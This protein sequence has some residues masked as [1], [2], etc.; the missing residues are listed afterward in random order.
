[1]VS[2]HETAD[3]RSLIQILHGVKEFEDLWSRAPL[4]GFRL[5]WEAVG[6]ARAFSRNPTPGRLGGRTNR[7]ALA[8]G[9][10]RFGAWRQANQASHGQREGSDVRDRDW[11]ELRGSMPVRRGPGRPWGGRRRQRSPCAGLPQAL[12]EAEMLLLPIR[13]SNFERGTGV[14]AF[15]GE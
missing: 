6:R 3:K 8:E 13:K 11:P 5:R 7:D 12:V 1:M 9:V 10:N 4:E 15:E 2:Q 14:E